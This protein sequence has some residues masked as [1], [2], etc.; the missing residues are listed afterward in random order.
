[1]LISKIRGG[2]FDQHQFVNGNPG[3][4]VPCAAARRNHGPPPLAEN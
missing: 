3:R 4:I 2:A 1:M